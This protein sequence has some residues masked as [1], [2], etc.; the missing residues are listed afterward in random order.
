DGTPAIWLMNGTTPT[1]Q[2]GLPNR[3]SSWK[4]IGTADYNADG[5]DDIL[6]QN[7]TTGDLTIDLM[8]GTSIASTVSIANGA[9][10]WHAV[11][12]GVF[13]GTPEIAWQNTD[14]TPAIWLFNGT[15][16]VV[17]S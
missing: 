11:S 8:N 16:P 1:L 12:T 7:T 10:S 17:E 2:V 5:D 9:P 6:L 3:G 4:V 14:G 13:N 15:S